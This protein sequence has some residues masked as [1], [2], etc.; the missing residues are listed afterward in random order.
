M[1][2]QPTRHLLA[3]TIA[4]VVASLLGAASLS[5]AAV[6]QPLYLPLLQSTPATQSDRVVFVSRQIPPDGSIYWDVPK[7]MP[8]VG[9]HSRFRVAAPGKLM[10]L[11]TS[12]GTRTLI[13]GSQPSSAS[14]D[15]VDVNAPAVSYDAS[16]IVFAGLP[17]RNYKLGPATNPGAWRLYVIKVDGTGLRQITASDQQLDMQQFGAAAAGLDSY[18]DTDPAWLPDGRIVFSS[19]GRTASRR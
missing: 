9:P 4:S 17:K 2:K 13:D 3:R 18:D 15:L 7:D 10:V 14:L 5:L 1:H 16:T 19:V 6:S 12:G 11:E 8:G